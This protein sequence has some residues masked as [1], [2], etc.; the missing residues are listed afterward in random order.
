MPPSSFS[1]ATNTVTHQAQGKT[2]FSCQ[3]GSATPASDPYFN[4]CD[5]D[6]VGGECC[7]V[8]EG[9]V[10]AGNCLSEPVSK[11]FRG[12]WVGLSWS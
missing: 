7:L 3:P 1:R 12:G 11:M 6:E 4:S 5:A 9:N 8:Y 2:N 10:V